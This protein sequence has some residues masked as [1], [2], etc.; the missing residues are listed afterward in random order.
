MSGGL[1]GSA[2]LQGSLTASGCQAWVGQVKVSFMPLW[3]RA[4]SR[5]LVLAVTLLTQP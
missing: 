4:Q 2:Q 1:A 3:Q 5:G